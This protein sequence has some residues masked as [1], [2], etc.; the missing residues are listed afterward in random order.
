MAWLVAQIDECFDTWAEGK[1]EQGRLRLLAGIIDL[2][3]RPLTE[4][5]GIRARGRSPMQRW[6]IIGSTVVSIRL[7]ESVGKFDVTDLRDIL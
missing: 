2:A 7:Y 1:T 4:L 3:D 6:A 5:P